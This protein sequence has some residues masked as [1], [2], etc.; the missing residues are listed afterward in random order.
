[1]LVPLRFWKNLFTI[2]C[3]LFGLLV[4][5]LFLADP[6]VLPVTAQLPYA[7]MLLWMI[8]WAH[9]G[10]L[11]CLYFAFLLF[12]FLTLFVSSDGVPAADPAFSDSL[13]NY[14]RLAALVNTVR[15]DFKQ[16]KS[17]TAVFTLTPLPWRLF[18]P[19]MRDLESKK[20]LTVVP[21]GCL[22]IYSIFDLKCHLAHALVRPRSRFIV[23]VCLK[24]ALILDQMTGPSVAKALPA[25]RVVLFRQIATAY[26]KQL[27]AWCVFA[28]LLADHTVASKYGSFAVTTWIQRSQL[29]NKSVTSC[30]AAKVVPLA[31]LGLFV[32]V[33]AN[34]YAT[35]MWLQEAGWLKSLR[36]QMQQYERKKTGMSPLLIRLFALQHGLQ[37]AGGLDPRPAASLFEDLPTLEKAVLRKEI[38]LPAGAP[39]LSAQECGSATDVLMRCMQDELNRNAKL[40]SAWQL[41]DLPDLVARRKQ[42]TAVYRPDP[43]LALTVPEREAATTKLFAAFL[44]IELSKRGWAASSPQQTRLLLR[45]GDKKLQPETVIRSLAAGLLTREKFL[46]LVG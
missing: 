28:D 17:R 16:P 21:L 3:K 20:R 32:P 37:Q 8:T 15:A 26:R 22:E 9:Y 39:L 34:S 1:M 18:A 33:A 19:D 46:L 6:S 25:W 12:R 27:M 36:K 24:Q 41:S 10:Q 45:Y 14:P 4:L 38:P 44:A 11:T 23:P 43:S 35:Y 42:V 29:A 7:Y 13:E 5:H 40:V 30:I 31:K 2:R